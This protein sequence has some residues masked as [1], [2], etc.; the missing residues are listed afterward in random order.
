VLTYAVAGLPAGLSLDPLTGSITGTLRGDASARS[1]YQI[2]VTATDAQGAATEVTFTLVVTNPVPAPADD[3]FL[4]QQDTELK[5]NVGSND[6]DP[7]GDLP[8]TFRI[9]RAPANG[10]VSLAASGAFT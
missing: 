8:L 9:G 6:Q 1:P 5:G 7:D 3:A 10:A 4:V 2:R